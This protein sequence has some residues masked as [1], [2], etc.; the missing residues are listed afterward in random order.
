MGMGIWRSPMFL[1]NMGDEAQRNDKASLQMLTT[2]TDN[3]T[4]TFPKNF[5]S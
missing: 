2:Y 5:I 3:S 1:I 4:M